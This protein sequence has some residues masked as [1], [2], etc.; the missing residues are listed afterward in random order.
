M[1]EKP[2]VEPGQ[3]I[4]VGTKLD[5]VVCAVR[6]DDSI[7]VVYLDH[8]DRAINEDAKWTGEIWDFAVEGPNG[9]YANQYKRLQ[10]YVNILRS[11]RI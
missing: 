2:N 6:E 8:G 7:E 4:T 1:A 5:T 11:G 3:W 10:E 9:G